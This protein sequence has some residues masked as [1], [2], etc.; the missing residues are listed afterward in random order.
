MG[1]Y[2]CE[3]TLDEAINSII[4]QTYQNWELIM[5]DDGSNDQTYAIAKNYED[6]YPEKITVL[7]NEKNIRLA[8]TL[9][10]CARYATGEYIAR[11]DGDDIST[12]NRLEIQVDFLK[13]NPEYDL[14]GSYMQAFDEN[15]EKNIIP[16][17][18]K[19]IKTDLPKFNPFHHATIVMKKSVF[20]ELQGYQVCKITSRA[21]DVDLWFRFFK[22]GYKG[23]NI[24]EVLYL[25]REDVETFSRRTFKNSV[26]ASR[27]LI[28]GIKMLQLPIG[29]YFF[30][31]KPIVSQMTPKIIKQFFREN[32]DKRNKGDKK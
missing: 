14:V 5:C 25:V 19:P 18:A 29:Y 9:N 12:E 24:A 27:V 1:I 23:Y 30:A 16:I 15:G 17:K 2:N 7:K 6:R 20:D 13:S 22:A 31:F 32:M 26:D 3:K 8:A 4:K 28:H 10:H 21:E 11:M